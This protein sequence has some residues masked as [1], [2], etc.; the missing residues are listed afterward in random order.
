MYKGIFDSHAHYD[1]KRFNDDR[2][3]LLEKVFASGVCAVMNAGADMRSS[4]TSV[5]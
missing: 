3:E 5:Q 2:F 1:D 4:R